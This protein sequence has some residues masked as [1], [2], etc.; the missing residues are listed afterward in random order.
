MSK[1]TTST[2]TKRRESTGI[3]A[4]GGK[5]T[6]IRG[7]SCYRGRVGVVERAMALPT[8]SFIQRVG[9]CRW[10]TKMSRTPPEAART[11]FSSPTRSS[12]M[13]S[14]PPSKVSQEGA[15]RGGSRAKSRWMTSMM[16]VT[17]VQKMMILRGSNRSV[18]RMALIVAVGEVIRDLLRSRKARR[19]PKG[20]RRNAY[21]NEA[22]KADGEGLWS[23][24]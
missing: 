1:V 9:R 23:H 17:T 15:R 7:R 12:H 20:S 4:G 21:S 18:K 6:L 19:R 14:S 3:A 2:I 22:G 10:T 11:S 16:R 5:V 24:R 8:A 13:A